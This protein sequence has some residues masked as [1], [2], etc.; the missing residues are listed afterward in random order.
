MPHGGEY[1]SLERATNSAKH[2]CHCTLAPVPRACILLRHRTS[3]LC[4][5]L[6]TWQTCRHHRVGAVPMLKTEK[7]AIT[8]QPAPSQEPRTMHRPPV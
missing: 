4:L 6:A 1:L 2:A 7:A 8:M 5:R 3:C